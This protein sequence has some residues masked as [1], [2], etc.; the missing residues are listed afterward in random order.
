MTTIR[1]IIQHL[2]SIAPPLYQEDYDNA[3][4]IVGDPAT[5]VQGVMVCLDST[6]AVLNEAL[7]RGCN[8]IVA[9]HPIVFRGLKR[10]NGKSYVERVVQQAIK[11]DLAI[12]AIHTNLDNVYYQGVNQRLAQQL[13]LLQTRILAPKAW[14]RRFEV[15][16]PNA[17]TYLDEFQARGL[18]DAVALGEQ[19]RG[20]YSAGQEGPLLAYLRQIAPHTVPQTWPLLQTSPQVGAGLIG[21]LPTPL[22]THDF[23]ALLQN[24]LGTG[25]IRHTAPLPQPITQVALCGGAGSFLLPAAL[26]QGAHAFVTADYKYHEFFDADQ[27]LLIADVGHYESEQ[28]TI[29]SL[30]EIISQKF[31]NFATYCTEANTNPVFY[32]NASRSE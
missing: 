28:F 18:Q 26:A 29:A 17:V 2:E 24:T 31:S 7:A 16:L 9:H 20:N 15:S 25:C 6:S 3:G 12:Y 8:L 4:L 5:P 13:G 14:Q 23:L 1:D 10:F 11:A 22:E 19:L 32:F 30:Q 27:R 21:A